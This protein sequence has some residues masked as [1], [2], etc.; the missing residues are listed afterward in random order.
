MLES[1]RRKLRGQNITLEVSE[2]AR[3]A[4]AQRGFDPKYGARPLRRLIQRELETELS[5]LLLRGELREGARLH[6]DFVEGRFTFRTEGGAPERE[7]PGT[8]VH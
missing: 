6:V 8:P 1:T 3:D 5:R 4:L 2:A 7:P